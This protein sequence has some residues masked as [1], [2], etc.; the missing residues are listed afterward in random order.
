MVCWEICSF[1]CGYQLCLKKLQR[2]R[3]FFQPPAKDLS[4]SAKQGFNWVI[5][6]FSRLRLSVE[7]S[8]W[9]GGGWK[10][11]LRTWM[12]WEQFVYRVVYE[13]KEKA[14]LWRGWA[15]RYATPG[16]LGDSLRRASGIWVEPSRKCSLM[17]LLIK[18]YYKDYER[19][20]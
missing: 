1:T 17:L 3:L 7:D 8:R 14:G 9:V 12:G 2:L 6:S 11:A 20:G 18:K 19:D 16:N 13:V 4:T 10:W 5:A 15:W